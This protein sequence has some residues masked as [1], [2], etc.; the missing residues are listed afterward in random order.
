MDGLRPQIYQFAYGPAG[1]A[2]RTFLKVL[3]HAVE[4]HHPHRLGIVPQEHRPQGSKT[5]QEIFIYGA[6]THQSHKSG[7]QHI[8]AYQQIGARIGGHTGPGTASRRQSAD[9]QGNAQHGGNR[10][11]GVA[12]TATASRTAAS[13]TTGSSFRKMFRGMIRTHDLFR[14]YACRSGMASLILV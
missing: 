8:P 7:L 11:N 2:Y 5:H 1:T 3:S 9:E 4:Q 14:L 10:P 12:R 6:T 13:G